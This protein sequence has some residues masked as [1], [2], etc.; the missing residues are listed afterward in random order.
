MH[1][2]TMVIINAPFQSINFQTNASGEQIVY[3][4]NV[5]GIKVYILAGNLWYLDYVSNR[6]R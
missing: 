2:L 5:L 3:D 1:E 4:R 6:K